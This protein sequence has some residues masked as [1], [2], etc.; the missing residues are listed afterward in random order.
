MSIYIQSLFVCSLVSTF[1]IASNRGLNAADAPDMDKDSPP[2]LARALPQRPAKAVKSTPAAKA[3]SDLLA[4]RI[5]TVDT[6]KK[7]VMVDIAGRIYV[8]KL[9]RDVQVAVKNQPASI[10]DLA[11]GQEISLAILRSAGRGL[12]VAAVTIQPSKTPV[13]MAGEKKGQDQS[14]KK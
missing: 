5:T 8:F 6:A 3:P 13:E 9:S 2:S 14:P 7:L 1:V 12:E 10:D 11:P 4:G